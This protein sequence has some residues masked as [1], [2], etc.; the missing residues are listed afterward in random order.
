MNYE[1]LRHKFIEH[2][3]LCITLADR[4]INKK[5]IRST[6]RRI[7]LGKKLFT[8]LNSIKDPAWIKLSRELDL[9]A[10]E[11]SGYKFNAVST[12]KNV[13]GTISMLL[14]GT[15]AINKMLDRK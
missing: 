10:R 14:I 2:I 6:K 9:A 4:K 13:F 8:H 1:L 3:K 5:E 7:A 11:S 15:W 12:F